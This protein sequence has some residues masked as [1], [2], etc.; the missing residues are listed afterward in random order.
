MYHIYPYFPLD[1][2][3]KWRCFLFKKPFPPVGLVGL[4]GP[5]N[6]DPAVAA[7]V[8]C[9]GSPCLQ[10][11]ADP[12]KVGMWVAIFNGIEL[13]C[14]IRAY[15]NII[16]HI[17][18]QENLRGNLP[19]MTLPQLKVGLLPFGDHE[20][21]WNMKPISLAHTPIINWCQAETEVPSAFV[22]GG[23]L[24]ICTCICHLLFQNS[25][26]SIDFQWALLR[27]P[28][29][30]S[31]V[32]VKTS[33]S[34]VWLSLLLVVRL[35]KRWR[36]GNGSITPDGASHAEPKYAICLILEVISYRRC[37]R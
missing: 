28:F 15:G 13:A 9:V 6:Q 25:N 23:S 29:F 8:P 11:N 2:L 30:I 36:E 12:G 16:N 35:V 17:G 14:C 1:L 27:F 22:G 21:L 37:H 10:P 31:L 4:V 5:P 20:T 34:F 33:H 19:K 7:L 3:I 18:T 26:M 24:H 32:C